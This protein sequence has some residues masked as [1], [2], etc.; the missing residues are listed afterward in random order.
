[1]R[2]LGNACMSFLSCCTN[3]AD[4]MLCDYRS[5]FSS[6][7]FPAWVDARGNAFLCFNRFEFLIQTSNALATSI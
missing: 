2:I 1:M 7:R 3:S 5:H 6:S 4:E